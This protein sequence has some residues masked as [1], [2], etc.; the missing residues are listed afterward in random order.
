MRC[1]E[2]AYNEDDEVDSLDDFIVDDE[3]LSDH[4]DSS[5]EDRKESS[6]EDVKI[7]NKSL[8]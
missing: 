4:K 2:T 5:D 1:Q 7:G 3:E 8:L 6:N